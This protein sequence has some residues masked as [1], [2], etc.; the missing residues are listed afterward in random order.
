MGLF[1]LFRQSKDAPTNDDRP[2]RSRAS[3]EDD[4]APPSRAKRR[5]GK[6]AG[7]VDPV[8]P[9]KKRARR[10]LIGAIA[11]AL[12]VV[13]IL[14]MLLDSEPK[15]LTTDI[16]IDIPS[17]DQPAPSAPKA[18]AGEATP[19]SAAADAAPQTDVGAAPAAVAPPALAAPEPK[20]I[21]KPAEPPVAKLTEKPT[22]PAAPAPEK[23]AAKAAD[24][25]AEAQRVRA[26]LE[27]RAAP[28]LAPAP[29]Q[30]AQGKFTIQVAALS[31]PDKVQELQTRLKG[32]GVSSYTQKVATQGGE[33]TRIRVGPFNNRDDAEKML[34][35]LVKLGFGS[36]KVVPD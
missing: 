12:G 34:Q 7:A 14:P 26:L 15:P 33:A 16:A 3:G 23:P 24:S 20:P 17:R 29:S 30:N 27:G 18:D 8:L 31:S 35:R 2:F 10:R 11:L 4:I 25:S 36:S 1:S 21:E 32:A 6:D 19:P 5:S 22:T 13:V 28:A 9:E